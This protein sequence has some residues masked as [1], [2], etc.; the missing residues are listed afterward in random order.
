MVDVFI[1]WS[2]GVKFG[3]HMMVFL[4]LFGILLAYE[5]QRSRYHHLG[6]YSWY[7]VFTAALTHVGQEV[8][9]S[10]LVRKRTTAF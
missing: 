5:I 1:L 3:F 6:D 10:F 2:S 9:Y 7:L 8:E 4:F